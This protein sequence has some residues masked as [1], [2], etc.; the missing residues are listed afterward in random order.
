[1]VPYGLDSILPYYLQT[2]W[3]SI[4]ITVPIVYLVI[5]FQLIVLLVLVLLYTIL[6]QIDDEQI[7]TQTHSQLENGH[8]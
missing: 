2:C 1:M 6:T 4:F 5:L 3:H 8:H 7:H